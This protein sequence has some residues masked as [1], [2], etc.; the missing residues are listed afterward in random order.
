MDAQS[1]TQEGN[2]L[3]NKEVV[4]TAKE[5]KEGVEEQS[6]GGGDLFLGLGAAGLSFELQQQ[7]TA[8][9]KEGAEDDSL[10]T[11]HY[12]PFPLA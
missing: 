5:D 9:R 3:I 2:E 4:W 11:S 12:L 10:N 1:P 7:E 6:G 8:N